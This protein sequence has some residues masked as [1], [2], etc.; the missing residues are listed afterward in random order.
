MTSK[1]PVRSCD[2]VDEDALSY[3]EIKALCAGNP[4][5]KE[6]MQ[7]DIEV[8]KLKMLKADHMSG[9]YRM[10]DELLTMYPKRIKESQDFIAAFHADIK[11]LE[12]STSITENGI[13]PMIIGNQTYTD[14][15]AAGEALIEACKGIET[16]EQVKIGEY[17]GFDMLL[18]F[19]NFNREFKVDLKGSMSH[20]AVLGDDVS[21]NITRINNAFERI[22]QRLASIETQLENLSNQQA[23]AKAELERPFEREQE[24]ADKSKR[25]AELDSMLNLDG[26]P[27]IVVMGDAEIDAVDEIIEDDGIAAKAV[28]TSGKKKPSLLET[29][30][31]NAE[32]SK[33]MFNNALDRNKP[34]EAMI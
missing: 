21:G 29:L 25:L 32:K 5:I 14:R 1:S 31:R 16:T 26:V 8:S 24:L 19:D 11:H 30:E 15:I 7:L 2:D 12:T 6:K 20:V 18:S 13:S 27:D 17:R 23:N 4:Q 34:I 33:E 28:P 22:P 3:A 9:Q 10:Q